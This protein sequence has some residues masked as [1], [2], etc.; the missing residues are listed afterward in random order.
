MDIVNISGITSQNIN[1]V[2]TDTSS[3]QNSQQADKTLF[4]SILEN[5]LSTELT[6]KNGDTLWAIAKKYG[7]S[8]SNL[9]KSNN[10]ANPDL[11]YVNQRINVSGSGTETTATQK[12]QTAYG[13]TTSLTAGSVQGTSDSTQSSSGSGQTS[14]LSDSE[15]IAQDYIVQHESG[16][17]YNARNGKY[18]GKYQLDSS[19]LNGDYSA[20]NQEKVA[21]K[22]VMQRYGS[23]TKAMEHWKE[24]NWY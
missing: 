13:T 24:N 21:E 16:G 1:S 7:T 22:Y 5:N 4:S 18:I 14:N 2:G 9:A 6:V 20:A 23:W 8:I 17:D 12:V 10:I 11:I 15:K 3:T 19:Y